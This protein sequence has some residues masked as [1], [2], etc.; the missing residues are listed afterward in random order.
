MTETTLCVD[1][2]KDIDESLAEFEARFRNAGASLSGFAVLP[3]T[4]AESRTLM[5][6]FARSWRETGTV[7]PLLLSW[8]AECFDQ[9][10]RNEDADKSF[11]AKVFSL[12]RESAHRPRQNFGRDMEL[13]HQVTL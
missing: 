7:S 2:S 12:V 8:A 3:E 9:I 11:A 6:Q 10:A 1:E 5:R 4:P 13:T